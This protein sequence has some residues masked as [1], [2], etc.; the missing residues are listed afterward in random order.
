VPTGELRNFFIFDLSGVSGPV[1]S[2]TLRISTRNFSS[3]DPTET[4]TVFDVSTSPT[5][6]AGG[7]GGVGAFND[8]GSGVSYGSRIYSE[9]DQGL[10]RDILLNA[11]AIAAIEGSLG[12]N[13]AL[14]GAVTSLSGLHDFEAI[15][16]ELANDPG[17]VSL[18]L[19][20]GRMSAVSEPA[21]I[22]LL[23]AGLAGLAARRYRKT[24]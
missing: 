4:Y 12:G 19:E 16:G 5:S 13:F 24:T 7:T 15:F 3:A 23:G 22:L 18:V 2:A 14:G 8:L 6:L 9:P 11:S 17:T 21:S 20:T 10:L 1:T